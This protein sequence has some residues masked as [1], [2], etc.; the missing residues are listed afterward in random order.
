MGCLR[1]FR[2]QLE[3]YRIF[4]QR[5][6]HVTLVEIEIADALVG[7]FDGFNKFLIVA[8]LGLRLRGE[9]EIS[10]KLRSCGKQA[11]SFANRTS[12]IR[13]CAKVGRAARSHHPAVKRL[14][15]WRG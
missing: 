13:G 1:Q 10:L 11:C 12:T 5:T 6:N 14:I 8:F 15:D 4:L 7:D 2:Q 9:V 3:I